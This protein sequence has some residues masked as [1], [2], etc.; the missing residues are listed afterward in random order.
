V[1][2][3]VKTVTISLAIAVTVFL[4]AVAATSAAGSDAAPPS[5][6]PR[7]RPAERRSRAARLGAFKRTIV[8]LDRPLDGRAIVDGAT[9]ADRSA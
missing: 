4:G 8:T 2:K 9:G 3:T 6:E 7:R 1:P 5:P